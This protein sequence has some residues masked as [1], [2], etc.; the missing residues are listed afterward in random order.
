MSKFGVG[1]VEY[2]AFCIECDA[3]I[4][5]TCEEFLVEKRDEFRDAGDRLNVRRLTKV[6]RRRRLFDAFV[7]RVKS[8]S[9][10]AFLALQ[11]EGKV[12]ANGEFIQWLLEWFS[13][14]DN[15]QGLLEF[16]IAIVNLFGAFASWLLPLLTAL[17]LSLAGTAQGQIL[18]EESYEPYTL[19]VLDV[20]PSADD[21]GYRDIIWQFTPAKISGM[22]QPDGKI[23]FTAPPGRYQVLASVVAGTRDGETVTLTDGSHQL[24]RASFV[25]GDAQDVPNDDDNGDDPPP[26]PNIDGA[27]V[28][29]VEESADRTIETA[30][31]LGDATYWATVV[32]RGMRWHVYDID[33]PECPVTA[34]QVAGKLPALIITDKTGKVLAVEDLPT[35]KTEIDAIIKRTTGK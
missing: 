5:E 26:I 29:I 9:V 33:S 21:A 16:I 24:H 3:D 19:I 14:P 23:L 7:E 25:I 17:T 10:P 22:K 28:L 1:S 15:W 4:R 6:L 32:D 13:N 34:D 31:L 11:A 18:C 2:A 30:I 35:K 12:G 8:D 20:A 27:I